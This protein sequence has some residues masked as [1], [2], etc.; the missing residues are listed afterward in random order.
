MQWLIGSTLVFTLL[1]CDSP[2]AG[3]EAAAAADLFTRQHRKHELH[4]SVGG[5]DCRV[6]LISGETEFEDDTVESIHYGTGGYDAFGGAEQFAHD[7]AFRAVVYRDPA[8]AFWTYGATTRDE[9]QSMP[10]CR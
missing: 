2:R 10:R 1:A 7:H 5:S 9:A 6:L 3:E 8:G 4:A